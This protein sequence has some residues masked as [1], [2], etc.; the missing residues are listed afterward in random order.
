MMSDNRK[1][2]W[3]ISKKLRKCQHFKCQPA[4]CQDLAEHII[5][6]DQKF[7][8]ARARARARARKWQAA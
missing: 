8:R 7:F 3:Q 4:K 6:D 2:E 5:Q 1:C